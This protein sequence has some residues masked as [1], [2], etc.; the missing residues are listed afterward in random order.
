MYQKEFPIDNKKV[1]IELEKNPTDNKV[2]LDVS[3]VG[4]NPIKIYS[5]D[6]DTNFEDLIPSKVGRSIFGDDKEH[7]SSIMLGELKN[8]LQKHIDKN[9]K[10]SE[11][12]LTIYVAETII[13]LEAY[14]NQILKKPF[15]EDEKKSQF[16]TYFNFYKMQIDG[17]YEE[18]LNKL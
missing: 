16:L 2:L 14:I 8:I 6:L 18:F 11:A 10:L 12:D 15:D 5:Q 13:F 7:I 4:L 3:Y 1:V 17:K 9:K